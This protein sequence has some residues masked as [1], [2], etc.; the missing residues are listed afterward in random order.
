MARHPIPVYVFSAI[1]AVLNA[2]KYLQTAVPVRQ[3][4]L[5]N[6]SYLL[7]ISHVLQPVLH[8]T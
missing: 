2:I 3:V 7:L 8:T 6:L 4:E 5:I 1:L